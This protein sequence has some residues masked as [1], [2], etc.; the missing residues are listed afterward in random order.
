MNYTKRLKDF[1]VGKTR[2]ELSEE[3]KRIEHLIFERNYNLIEGRIEEALELQ[4]EINQYYL[5]ENVNSK[6][7]TYKF[8]L[9]YNKERNGGK[10]W[11]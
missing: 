2:Y 4:R 9:Q 5:W 8:N 6:E 11:D 10:K 3:D 1:I 7:E